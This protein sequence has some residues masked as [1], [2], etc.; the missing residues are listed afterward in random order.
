MTIVS[1]KPGRIQGLRH[2]TKTVKVPVDRV[3]DDVNAEEFDAIQ[4]P[5]GALNADALRGVPEAQSLLQAIQEAGKP[6]AAIGHAPW[7]LISAGLV[8]GRRLTSYHTIRDDVRNAGGNWVNQEV[9]EDDNWVTSRQPSDLPAF[10]RAMLNLFA[11]TAAT[12]QH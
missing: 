1:L 9:V 4:L 10:N 8:R 3:V 11:R 2:M 5:G 7:V 12:T 6:V